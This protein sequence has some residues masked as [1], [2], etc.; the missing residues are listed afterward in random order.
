MTPITEQTYGASDLRDGG[1]LGGGLRRWPH[2]PARTSRQGVPRVS[3]L[4]SR[5]NSSRPC[6]AFSQN[7]PGLRSRRFLSF[8][9]RSCMGAGRG[10]KAHCLV[11]VSPRKFCPTTFTAV[12]RASA[13]GIR[14]PRQLF[15]ET[16]TGHIRQDRAYPLHRP[17]S[18]VSRF[19][20]YE[21]RTGVVGNAQNWIGEIQHDQ[22]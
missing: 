11:R 1:A 18:S 9:T 13:R 22:H 8:R 17:F 5:V 4:S 6:L 10:L 19:D 21:P 7:W 20:A 15:N 16:R 12:G 14:E 2:M 3:R